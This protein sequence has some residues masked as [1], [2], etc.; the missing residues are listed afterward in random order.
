MTY[1]RL[2]LLWASIVF[3]LP[4]V[5]ADPRAGLN[6]LLVTIDTVRADHLGCYGRSNAQTASIDGLASSGVVFTRAFSHVPLTL[7]AHA[8]ILVGKTPPAHG[9][10][11]NGRFAVPEECL[12][13]AEHL[14]ASGYATGAFIGGYPLHSRFGLA[15][16]FDV[17]DDRLSSMPGISR[18]FAERRAS[19]VADAALKWLKG[20]SSPWFAWVHLYDPHDPYAPPEPFLSR[21]KDAPYDGE[22]AYVDETVGR[23]L[24][25]L[26]GAGLTENTV[27]VLVGDHGESLGQHGE[28]THGALAYNSTLWIPLIV[29][30]PG[31][32]P[33]RVDQ[34]VTHVD[35]FP[36]ICEALS[37]RQ[38][39][40]LEGRTLIPAMRGQKLRP[41]PVYFECLSPYYGRGWA[42]IRGL[43]KDQM[44]FIESPIPELYDLGKDFD[45]TANLA[46]T[47]SLAQFREP[48]SRILE[49]EAARKPESEIKIDTAAIDKL[50]SLGYVAGPA[51]RK[52]EKFGPEDDVKILLP[53][54]EKSMAALVMN[55]EGRVS[56]AIEQLKQL[57]SSRPDMD[58]AYVN[59]A[60]V[61]EAAGRTAEARRMFLDGLEALPE[62]YDLLTH[63]IRFLV[64]AGD[65]A[66]AVGLADAHPLPQ[67]ESDLKI[68]I[69]LG[70]CYRNLAEY[71]K[72]KACYETAISID[73]TY[74]VPYNNMGTLLLSMPRERADPS[75]LG[76]AVGYFK[77]ALELDPGYAA[78]YYGLGQAYYG[79]GEYDRSIAAMEKAEGL[80]HE[81]KDALFYRGMALYRTKRYLEAAPVLEAY[82]ENAPRTLAGPDRKRLEEII[83]FCRA[84]K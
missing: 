74:P 61:Y 11:D 18:E 68:W 46:G 63:A 54:Y 20:R 22:V 39:A 15:Q 12:T 10:H 33:A 69:D 37:L 48:L 24:A 77:K 80:D 71:D 9:V 47:R 76:Q 84:R 62:S 66:G 45:E 36:T 14:K 35:I 19:D 3:A 64:V 42:P 7:P 31:W 81:L 43:I 16:G 17:Y 60:L 34:V 28:T 26:R 67:M 38:P 58:A 59:L 79:M 41:A 23:L 52:K 78:G 44:K 51:A 8:N 70:I 65:F 13:L 57:I 1:R 73:P 32:R 75:A 21:F 49:A 83:S 40:G 4:G 53:Y 2:F 50:R 72:A 25:F 6:L 82:L 55:H 56:E 5:A 29:K 30:M 27:L